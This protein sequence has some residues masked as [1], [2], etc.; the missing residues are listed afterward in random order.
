MSGVMLHAPVKEDLLQ[1][2]VR[3]HDLVPHR[4][5]GNPAEGGVQVTNLAEGRFQEDRPPGRG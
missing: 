1:V 5:D 3:D 2:F 4:I